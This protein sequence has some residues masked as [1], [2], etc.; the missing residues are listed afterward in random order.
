MNEILLLKGKFEQKDW[1]SHFGH[2]NI[3]KNK[4]VTAEH[5]INL[6][7]DLCNVYQF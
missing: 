5:L 4:F 3:P 6:K 7:N 1:S 2:S